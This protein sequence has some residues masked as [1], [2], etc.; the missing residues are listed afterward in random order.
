[1]WNHHVCLVKKMNFDCTNHKLTTKHDINRMWTVEVES[2]TRKSDFFPPQR[3]ENFLWFGNYGL[4]L[5]KKYLFMVIMQNI[6][7]LSYL[8]L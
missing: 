8:S 2:S 5:G 4:F 3:N 1:M 6:D 7:L